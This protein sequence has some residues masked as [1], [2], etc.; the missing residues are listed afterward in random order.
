MAKNIDLKK[1]KWQ[2]ARNPCYALNNNAKCLDAGQSLS[3]IVCFAFVEYELKWHVWELAIC[4]KKA[5]T[6]NCDD[7][8]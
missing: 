3:D 5:N 7:E 8:P 4:C 2:A 6:V 1:C